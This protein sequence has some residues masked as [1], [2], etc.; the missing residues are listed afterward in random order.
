M[1]CVVI[2]DA[3]FENLSWEKEFFAK[4]GIDLK[5]ANTFNP[6]EALPLMVDAD[7]IVTNRCPVQRTIIEQLRKCKAIIR[8]GVGVDNVD[9][10]AATERGIFVCNVPDYS[11]DDVATHAV[12]LLLCCWRRVHLGNSSLK[13]GEWQRYKAI[14][15]V[16]R[17]IG[18]FVGLFGFGRI[19]KRVSELLYPFGFKILAYDPYLPDEEFLLHGAEKV[20]FDFLLELSDAISLHAPLTEETKGIF[21]RNVFSRMKRG[22][23][24]VNTARGGLVDEDALLWALD[25][26]IVAAA[27]LD[28]FN[29]EPN[30]NPE[31]VQHPKVIA[32]PHWAWYSEEAV[33]ELRLKVAEQAVQAIK[34]QPPTYTINRDELDGRK[35]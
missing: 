4:H 23:I 22:I 35:I 12:A 34:G 29:N 9:V 14:F 13:K 28:V 21:N 27:G 7:V 3:E 1:P 32:T 10:K 5:F 8:Y 17:T 2:T 33:R 25:E 11:T 31:L 16:F 26:G 24:F 30:P 18:K 19:A 20:E 15:P 6:E